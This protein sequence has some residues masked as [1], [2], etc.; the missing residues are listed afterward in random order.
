MARL[1]PLQARMPSVRR[2]GATTRAD[3]ENNSRKME[4]FAEGK[5]KKENQRKRKKNSPESN[6]GARG[7]LPPVRQAGSR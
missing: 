2:P 7:L 6:A 3:P 1:L 4:K 5:E